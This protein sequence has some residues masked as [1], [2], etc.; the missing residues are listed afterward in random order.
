M[1][2]RVVFTPAAV[3]LVRALRAAQGPLIFHLSGGC[4]E[5]SAPMCL[6]R[7]DFRPGRAG[8]AARRD[9]GV[10]L[11][12]RRGAVCLLGALPDRRGRD[13][14]RRRQF[15]ARGPGRGAIF[16]SFAAVNEPGGGHARKGRSVERPMRPW[17]AITNTSATA[18]SACWRASI[19][20]P[21]RSTP[22]SRIATEA[23]NSLIPQASR[24]RLSTH[25]AIKLI[26]DIIPRTSRR[27]PRL[28]SRTSLSAASTTGS[29]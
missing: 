3:A 19:C 23:A 21:A 24:R 1:A 26:L 28:G 17:P 10:P 2:D 5:G 16:G 8:P 11:L 6:R 20:S 4:C 13:G 25:M 7:T 22:S 9:R 12:C 15:F 27:R 14:G 29:R 18:R